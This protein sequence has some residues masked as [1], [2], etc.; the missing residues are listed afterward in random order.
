MLARAQCTA[1]PP[2]AALS[3]PPLRRL[4]ALRR[5]A[6]AH[7]GLAVRAAAAAG[8]GGGVSSGSSSGS[9]DP[10]SVQDCSG[11]SEA[12]LQ[13]VA[14]QL[15]SQSREASQSKTARLSD[16][17]L[18]RRM[19]LLLQLGFSQAA[20][21]AAI[22]KTGGGPY[23]AEQHISE[24]VALLRQW[25]FSQKQLN[26]VLA[27]SSA[28]TRSAA[29]VEGVLAWLQQEFRLQ[30]GEVAR[31]C[32]RMPSLLAQKQETLQAN[33]RAFEAEFQPTSSAIAALAA[34][35][36][37]GHAGFLLLKSETLKAKVCQLQQL[38]FVDDR[39]LPKRIGH[40]AEICG[41]D[42]PGTIQPRLAFLQALTGVPDKKL[43]SRILSCPALFRT[44]EELLQRK[45]NALVAAMGEQAAQDILL[46]R[47]D[48]L[49]AVEER[50]A[51]NITA[52]QQ[53]FGVARESAAG[54]LCANTRLL[55]YNMQD[56]TTASK[57]CSRVA[58]WQQVYSLSADAAAVRCSVMLHQSL[59]TVAPR[60][61]FYQQ[62]RPDQPLPPCRAFTS[63][64]EAFCEQFK[65]NPLEFAA[66]KARWLA[67]EEGRALC[68]H[69]GKQS[70]RQR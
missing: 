21:E 11:L 14:E 45:R 61:A 64:N 31:A 39:S 25:G 37:K 36:Q 48:V 15:M 30:H 56:S 28:F 59:C 57:L 5:Y 23:I 9:P 47:P 43:A 68:Q 7:G 46:M 65:L 8:S 52:L 53:L 16:D 62:Q 13:A 27:G 17:T 54:I 38:F 66:F 63:G 58:F 1:A 22:R 12:Q 55:K 32:G 50:A 29:D 26:S 69:E 4:Q 60:V 19:A 20:I 3:R 6:R 10:S 24:I 18:Q 51:L 35:L 2:A 49:A 41:F 44:S 33:W 67:S 42:I 34:V 40:M 70:E